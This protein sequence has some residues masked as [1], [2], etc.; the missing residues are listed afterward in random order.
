MSN[1]PKE[2]KLPLTTCVKAWISLEH[3]LRDYSDVLDDLDTKHLTDLYDA[4][5][6]KIDAVQD[7]LEYKPKTKTD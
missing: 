1:A 4:I 7:R 3:V 5:T 2:I 6:G